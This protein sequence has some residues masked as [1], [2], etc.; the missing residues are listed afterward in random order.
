VS[1]KYLSYQPLS[2]TSANPPTAI[3]LSIILKIVLFPTF[4]VFLA[5]G[6]MAEVAETHDPWQVSFLSLSL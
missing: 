1:C 6:G 4:N 2:A 3:S 5:L